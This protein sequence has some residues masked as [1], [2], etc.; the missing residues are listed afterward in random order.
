MNIPLLIAIIFGFLAA[1]IFACLLFHLFF[2]DWADYLEALRYIFQPNWLSLFR[3][4]Y[5]RDV[6][7]SFKASLFHLLILATGIL[8]FFFT[9]SCLR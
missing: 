4:E 5:M 7:M 3:G 6:W 1:S 8:V 2:H 9:L